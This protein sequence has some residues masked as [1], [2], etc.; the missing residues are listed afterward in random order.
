MKSPDLQ[1]WQVM[2]T[3]PKKPICP[4]RLRCHLGNSSNNHLV[5]S[6]PKLHT[7]SYTINQ[8]CR[9]EAVVQKQV[10]SSKMAQEGV[11]PQ[12]MRRDGV[13]ATP[14]KSRS[15]RFKVLADVNGKSP[16]AAAAKQV[17]HAAGAKLSTDP[18]KHTT[19]S[20]LLQ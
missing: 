11:H 16:L 1:V 20:R 14:S 19:S 12:I 17:D 13:D 5:V 18:A 8:C 6:N 15:Y 9:P 2:T 7:I 3:Q 10:E 4:A